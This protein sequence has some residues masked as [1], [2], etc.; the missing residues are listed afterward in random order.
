MI[1]LKLQLR[2]FMSYRENVPP[3]L[4]DGF[5]VACLCGDNGHG[6]SALL[7]AITWAL[8]GKARA[9]SE[10][11]LIHHGRTEMEV[12]YEFL[13][14]ESRYRVLR[15]RALKKRGDSVAGVGSLDLQICGE[16]GYRSITSNTMHET[17]RR[18]NELL[19]MEY[20]T[21]VNSAFIL[22]GK[23]DAFTLK[24]PADRKQVLA[25]LLGLAAYDALE[26][27]ARDKAK[28]SEAKR[29]EEA[30][31]KATME[32]EVARRP[33]Y[34]SQAEMVA[35]DLAELAERLGERDRLL[36]LLREEK[37]SLEQDQAR[38]Q[39]IA[40]QLTTAERELA[41]SEGQVKEHGRRLADCEAALARREV[42]EAGYRRLLEGRA[43]Y[44]A[45]NG[46][47]GTLLKLNE[48]RSTLARTVDEARARLSAD[49][50]AIVGAAEELERRAVGVAKQR[51]ELEKARQELAAL[52][53]LEPQQEQKR[54]LVQSLNYQVLTLREINERI[55][56]EGTLLKEKIDLISHGGARCPVC[57][58]ELGPDGRDRLARQFEAQRAELRRDYAEHEKRI[59][60]LE[61][62]SAREM[63][64]LAGIQKS[65]ER[66]LALE[67]AVAGLEKGLADA[68]EAGAQAREKRA[69][70]ALLAVRL[71]KRDYVAEQQAQL[72]VVEGEVAALG[73]DAKE[74]ER[75]KA[76][77]TQLAPCEQQQ[78]KLAAAEAT[79]SQERPLLAAAERLRDRWQTQLRSARERRE[80]L[81][82]RLRRLPTLQA[83]LGR[84]EGEI[85][86]LVNQQTDAHLRQG[87]CQQ[88]L[89]NCQ[90]LERQC[91]EL[92]KAIARLA[93]EKSIFDELVVAFGK[94]GI[95]AMIIET[96][97][98]ELEDEANE[99]LAR[100]TDGRM[101]LRFETQRAAKSSD[102]VIETLD[103]RI[104]DELG[105]RSYELFSG[106]E[107][108]K[109]NFAIR[110][111]L[112]KLLA[113][114]AG[115]RLELLV[116]DE[117]FGTQD[118]Q[119]RE[120]LV[121][122]INAVSR[123]FAKILVITHIEELKDA[124]PVRIDVVKTAEGSQFSM[125]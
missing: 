78:Q 122:A 24:S 63:Q 45:L 97:V 26:E 56:Q 13:L 82:L 57:E 85:E 89:N 68:E 95:Q 18:L 103:I 41:E 115:A 28:E 33:E 94:K 37:H 20:D 110:V 14:G 100:M 25:D 38:L 39:E 64:T 19:R 91:G 72:A 117:G 21:F 92:A 34:E 30:A 67:R 62:D 83:D 98:P 1:P 105:T 36:A 70:A 32:L 96:A 99:L 124:F 16:A 77:V 10:D 66:K 113:R 42:V 5:R 49:H 86:K 87:R 31:R 107:A 22:Q 7:D 44:E 8:W 61:A 54:A 2:N 9:K 27:L 84:L 104:A 88:M 71:E 43:Q 50:R 106:G 53:G 40:Q 65:L 51:A 60:E 118:A 55:K 80:E 12:E 108:F 46:R 29:R 48:R 35:K 102:A 112:S 101:R 69:A 47:L 120:R 75:V 116:M 52:A 119:G 58:S 114:R 15:K 81:A 121:E 74:H 59:K 111:A 6:K 125:S 93:A 3:L 79:L 4:F 90:Y 73:Y 76:E 11:E 109:V 123:D 17:Q 23:A